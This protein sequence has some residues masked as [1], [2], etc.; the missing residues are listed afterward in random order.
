MREVERFE[1]F[2][3]VREVRSWFPRGFVGIVLK[4]FPFYEVMEFTSA[5]AGIKDLMNF[6]FLVILDDHR[7][8]RWKRVARVWAS[9]RFKERN[10]EDGVNLPVRREFEAEGGL[11]DYQVDFERSKFLFGKLSCWS[12]GFDVGR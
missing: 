12:G 6:P 9:C 7:F 1:E 4:A 10:V 2:G 8:G 3:A 11:R 5:K